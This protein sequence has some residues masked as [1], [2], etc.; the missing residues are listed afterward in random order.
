MEPAEPPRPSRGVPRVTGVANAL[1]ALRNLGLFG[2]STAPAS[3]GAGLLRVPA[4]DGHAI[5]VR[6]LGSGPP[7]V[8]VH[9]LGCAY[10]HWMPVARRLA[11][12]HRV[13]IPDARG[14]GLARHHPGRPVTLR[15][16]AF[17]LAA[18][19]EHS[20]PERAVLVGHSM[21]ALT[22]MQYLR[23]H[24]PARV[25]A[26]ALVDQS[27]RVVTDDDW[28]LGLFGG[29]SAPMLEGL[30]AGARQDLAGTL[31]REVEAAGA[32]WLSRRLAA[33]AALGRLLRRW[34]Q[35]LDAPALLD[36]TESL[37]RAD[38]RALFE[39]FDLPLLVVLGARSPHYA[40]V[41]LDDWY[42]RRV[43]HA[44]VTVYAQ[45]GHSPHFTEP[46]R[47]ARELRRFIADHA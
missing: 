46:E 40:G 10:A 29:C 43:P 34:L 41:P 9:G 45:G 19:L 12:A 47:F 38:H 6:V 1:R 35:Q 22:V 21:G 32:A 25:A 14:H 26:V 42:R 3:D 33:N 5:P 36:L 11:V 13:L 39:R 20:G 8:L 27:P 7:V 37:A 17:D 23:D 44:S 31:Q 15:R 16:L 4:D 18:L 30:I 2:R 28:R 24:G